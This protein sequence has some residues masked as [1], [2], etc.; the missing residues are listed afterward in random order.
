[1]KYLIAIFSLFLIS[2]KQD[3]VKYV[4]PSGRHWLTK[5]AVNSEDTLLKFYDYENSD[6]VKMVGFEKNGF[7]NDSWNYN[8]KDGIETI[9][10]AQYYDKDLKYRT[11]VLS[12]ADSTKHGDF[13]TKFLY[14]RPHEKLI[15]S[16]SVNSPIKN[17]SPEANYKSITTKELATIGGRVIDYVSQKTNYNARTIYIN[18]ITVK[19]PNGEVIYIR[20]AFS[21]I[22]K[23]NFIEFSVSTNKNKSFLST[24]IFNAVFTKFQLN[25]KRFYDPVNGSGLIYE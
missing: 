22:D 10:W 5:E 18:D 8:T 20:G 23:D 4:D 21:F 19:K 15:L 13:F 12:Y 11:N 14:K 24:E 7:R 17:N 16:I 25:K 3:K 9:I 1:M 2:C 6:S